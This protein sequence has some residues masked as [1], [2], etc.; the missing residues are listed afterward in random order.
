MNDPILLRGYVRHVLS[1]SRRPLDEAVIYSHVAPMT[2]D[3][4]LVDELK[5][6]LLW[7]ESRD[8]ISA[9]L[10]DDTAQHEWSLTPKGRTKEDL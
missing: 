10:N 2:R 1:A 5:T 6:A 3:P 4:L 7:N 9:T 8:Y